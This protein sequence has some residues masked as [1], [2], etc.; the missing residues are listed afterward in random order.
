MYVVYVQVQWRLNGFEDTKDM[1]R[2]MRPLDKEPS[3]WC[4]R[5]DPWRIVCIVQGFFY[6]LTPLSSSSSLRDSPLSNWDSTERI[7][8]WR[9]FHAF[10][11]VGWW[12][13]YSVVFPQ[14]LEGRRP[15]WYCTYS[16]CLLERSGMKI[17]NH[18]TFKTI[19]P[20][21]LKKKQITRFCSGVWNRSKR[22][23]TFGFLFFKV[24]EYCKQIDRWTP[25][26]WRGDRWRGGVE[27]VVWTYFWGWR[28][29]LVEWSIVWRYIV[30]LLRNT[31]WYAFNDSIT[32][33][34]QSG[35]A[36][37]RIRG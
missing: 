22:R 37:E 14:D 31:I 16:T 15:M 17:L 21:F 9:P 30:K 18:M 27:D 32:G 24:S 33:V 13:F 20:F 19:Q 34:E 26:K 12:L 6:S 5:A 7:K 1:S 36:E 23:H 29:A 8:E 4:I 3:F 28:S 10:D 11:V 25:K 2:V 35:C